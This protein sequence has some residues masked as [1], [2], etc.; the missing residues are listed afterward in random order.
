VVLAGM[1]ANRF[2]QLGTTL[3]AF[4]VEI[5]IV[6]VFV[7]ALVFAP[8]LMFSGQLARTKRMG[9]SEYGMLAERYVRAFDTK[10]LRGGA[11]A[12]ESLMGSADIQSL[13]DL[14]NSFEVVKEM[15]FA[16]ITR[17]AILQLA[18]ATL[19]PVAP[20]MLTVMPLEELIRRLIGTVF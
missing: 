8:L 13:A 2:F 4:K 1:I 19:L 16:P 11:A 5:A 18:V 10:W 6:V 12:D 14:N 3:P 15:R 7:Q 20:L 17:D 9:L